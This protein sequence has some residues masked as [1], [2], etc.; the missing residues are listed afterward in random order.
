MSAFNGVKVFAATLAHHR[1]QIGETV[2]AWLQAAKE[3][4]SGFKVVDII[5]RQSSDAKFHCVTIVVF[6]KEDHR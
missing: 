2:T 6:Y 4:R 5:V 3:Q 1:D